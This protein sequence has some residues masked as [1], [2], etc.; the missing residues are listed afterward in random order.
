[1]IN[2]TRRVRRRRGTQIATPHPPMNGDIS[3]VGYIAGR[4]FLKEV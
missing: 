1:M 3:T 2:P 4:Y